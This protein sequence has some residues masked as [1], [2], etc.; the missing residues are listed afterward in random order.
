M[1][2]KLPLLAV[3]CDKSF[4]VISILPEIITYQKK[5]KFVVYYSNK[6]GCVKLS[7]L[8]NHTSK[9]FQFGF[10]SNLE[11]N[12]NYGKNICLNQ[13]SSDQKIE[14]F[15]KIKQNFE[16]NSLRFFS[17]RLSDLFNYDK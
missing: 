2:S 10:K 14:G 15:V 16:E 4:N 6:D 1:H 13:F 11:S 5:S 3:G 12:R 17:I 9:S 8:V 7:D